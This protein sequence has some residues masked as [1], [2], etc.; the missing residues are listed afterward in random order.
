M[1][2]YH[3]YVAFAIT[4]GKLSL[5]ERC[6]QII[7]QDKQSSFEQLLKKDNSLAT[8]MYE[9]STGLFRIQIQELFMPNNH[10]ISKL[11][12]SLHKKYFTR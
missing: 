4:I 11:W 2:L 1:S 7:Y 3:G 9:I 6:L 12:I 10:T 8:E 5:H